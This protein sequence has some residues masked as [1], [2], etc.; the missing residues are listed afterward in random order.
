VLV[1]K[2][3]ERPEN[4]GKI[5]IFEYGYQIAKM[6]EEKLKPEFEDIQAQDIFDFWDG[7]DFIIRMTGN[8]IPDSR[9]GK[10]VVVPNYEKSSFSESSE[11]F[12]G[13][14]EKIDE[15]YQKTYDLSEFVDPK[16]FK[17]FDEVAEKFEKVT[18]VPYNYL[19]EGGLEEHAE[20]VIKKQQEEFDQNTPED[21]KSDGD[22]DVP[23]E[24]DQKEKEDDD[25]D[26]VARL[27]KA[28]QGA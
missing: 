28:A 1:I 23:S 5:M 24:P 3:E 19:K 16:L 4:E 10:T 11:L 2:D 13:D 27:L 22:D 18:G 7:S 12:D 14:D 15:I 6:V 17:S 9:T 21:D 26:P 8:K 20:K 25:D